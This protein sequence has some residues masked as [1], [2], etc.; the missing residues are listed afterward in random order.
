M[1]HLT[2]FILILIT[3]KIASRWKENYKT[4]MLSRLITRK[5]WCHALCVLETMKSTYPIAQ[6]ITLFSPCSFRMA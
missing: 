5:W 4:Q 3:L 1:Y 6:T 2:S